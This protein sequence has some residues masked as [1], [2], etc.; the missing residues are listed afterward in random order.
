MLNIHN[1]DASESPGRH[2]SPAAVGGPRFPPCQLACVL[3]P[4][5]GRASG[6]VRQDGLGLQCVELSA[7][8]CPSHQINNQNKHSSLVIYHFT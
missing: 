6:P 2:Q 1:D 5:V 7:L 4:L 3:L 8:C